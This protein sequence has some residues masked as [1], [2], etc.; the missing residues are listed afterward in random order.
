MTVSAVPSTPSLAA[1]SQETVTTTLMAAKKAKGMS[2]ADLEAALG[3]DEV[4]I[5]SLFYGQ[6]TAS[7]E[8]AEKL[9]ELLSLD[10]A[11]TAAL[12]EF[13]TKG[14]LDPVIPT[15][16]LIYRFYEIMQVYGMPMKDVIQEKFGDGIMSAI[17]F[18]LN[19]DKVE[20]PAGDRVKVTMC[21]KFLPYKKW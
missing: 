18:T 2:F 8:E 21:G 1:P 11:I 10:P 13:P 5:A 9:A 3:L 17:D 15:D 16:P 12:Q 7:K 19:I 4:W 6:A 20:D 14:S